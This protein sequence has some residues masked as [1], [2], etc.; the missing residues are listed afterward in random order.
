MHNETLMENT[1]EGR[2]MNFNFLHFSVT[3]YITIKLK[4]IIRSI[5]ISPKSLYIRIEHK[6]TV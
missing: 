5:V 3:V 4:K 6:N 2:F 1:Y